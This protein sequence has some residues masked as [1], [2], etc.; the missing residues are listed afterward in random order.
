MWPRGKSFDRTRGRFK[1]TASLAEKVNASDDRRPRL[2]KISTVAQMS[3]P[4]WRKNGENHDDF[5]SVSIQTGGTCQTFRLWSG[6]ESSLSSSV[7]Q[8]H[9]YDSDSC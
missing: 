1:H 6:R 9:H 4:W 3:R 5:D 2:R 7:W 8:P